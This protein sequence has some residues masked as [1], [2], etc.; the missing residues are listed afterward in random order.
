MT[1]GIGRRGWDNPAVLETLIWNKPAVGSD[2]QDPLG[3]ELRMSTRMAG[4]LLHCITTVTPRA[5]YYS[6]LPWCVQDYRDHVKGEAADRGLVDAIRQREKVLAL[7]C[8]T[9]HEGA[10]CDY[11][12]VVGSR[13]AQRKWSATDL[14][15]S[16]DLRRYRSQGSLAWYQY[17]NSLV[18]LGCFEEME[19]TEDDESVGE[20]GAG[21]GLTPDEIRLTAFGQQLAEAFGS[22]LGR[23]RV[24]AELRSNRVHVTLRAV[25]SVAA[26]GG[27]CEI[28]E[29][30][31]LDRALLREMFFDRVK[32]PGRAHALRRMS[33]LLLMDLVRQCADA[34][35]DLDSDVLGDMLLYGATLADDKVVE[36]S[37]PA[38]LEPVAA[39][40]RMFYLHNHM[41][42]AL[43]GAFLGLIRAVEQS[44]RGNMRFESIFASLGDKS[45]SSTFAKALGV[46]GLKAFS[47]MTPAQVFAAAGVPQEARRPRIG[48]GVSLDCPLAEWRLAEVLREPEWESLPTPAGLAICLTLLSTVLLR[49]DE[50][51]ETE[52]ALWCARNVRDSYLDLAPPLVSGWLGQWDRAWWH[53]RWSELAPMLLDRFVVRQHEVLGYDKGGGSD[54]MILHCN[55]GVLS[56]TGEY[57]RV[58]I[59]NPRFR[60]AM[61]ILGDLGL[62]D[63]SEVQLT[64]DGTAWLEEEMRHT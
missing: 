52:S 21:A 41:S 38:R 8:V 43:E 15:E 62:V 23:P 59:G 29:N 44:E 9:H 58:T 20:E 27:I 45:I 19:P 51:R 36:L 26:R 25:E 55:D 40:W 64:A 28:R 24:L 1:A 3:L 13:E 60:N 14:D 53:R 12:G 37:Y 6:F 16:F 42:V 61:Q 35:I 63:L 50:L 56:A 4:Q 18:N 57:G 31:S 39:Y 34:G 11:G 33:L 2:V 47:E 30:G 49:F 54:S 46:A 32:S 48:E 5:R 10:T 17:F 22:S 7:G